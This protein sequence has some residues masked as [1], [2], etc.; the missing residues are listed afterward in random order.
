M[1]ARE[2]DSRLRLTPTYRDRY[3]QGAPPCFWLPGFFFTPSFATAALQNYARARRLPIDTVGFDFEILAVDEALYAQP[4]PEGVYI[5]GLYLEGCA[6]D[7]A[8][9]QLAES[10]PKVLFEPCPVIWL[11]PMPT[12]QFSDYPHYSS[13]VYRTAERK[14]E[15]DFV[16]VSLRCS[17]CLIMII[18]SR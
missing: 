12:Q 14:G 17:L 13:P 7:S 10:R 9:C 8:A 6:W 11:K 5:Y 2:C 18:L 1:P 3:D 4:P 15:F 16:P